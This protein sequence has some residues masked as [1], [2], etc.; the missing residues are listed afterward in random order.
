MVGKETPIMRVRRH[1][2]V[3]T[4]GKV[5]LLGSSTEARTLV[6]RQLTSMVP[7]EGDGGLGIGLCRRLMPLSPDFEMALQTLIGGLIS[8]V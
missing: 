8:K 3:Y 6:Q 2:S 5:D 4:M 1:W 7:A